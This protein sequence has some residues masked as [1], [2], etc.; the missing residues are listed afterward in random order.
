MCSE[1]TKTPAGYIR[2]N[3]LPNA[4]GTESAWS[5][6]FVVLLPSHPEIKFWTVKIKSSPK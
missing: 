4:K 1:G 2:L 5:K 3:H 6:W